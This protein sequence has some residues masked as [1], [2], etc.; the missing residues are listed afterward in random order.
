[1]SF[2]N[3]GLLKFLVADFNKFIQSGD[4]LPHSEEGRKLSIKSA[5]PKDMNEAQVRQSFILPLIEILGWNK[6]NPLEV[7]AEERA[8]GGFLD[9][10]LSSKGKTHFVIEIKRP[11]VNL[12]ISSPSGRSAAY[13]GIGYARSFSENPITI[14]T[15]FER[16]NIYHSYGM[17]QESDVNAN[18]LATFLW[19]DFESIE[20]VGIFNNITRS[21]CEG[22]KAKGFFDGLIKNKDVIRKSKPLNQK[23]L[24]DFEK[25][26]FSLGQDLYS[27]GLKEPIAL[28]FIVQRV[29][30]KLILIRNLQD[31]RADASGLSNLKNLITEKNI[32]KKLSTVVFPHFETNLSEDF[33][34]QNELEKKYLSTISDVI[35]KNIILKT[36][37]E[38]ENGVVQDIYDFSI[39]P[40][41]LLGYAYEQY[42][43]KVFVVEKN[44]LKLD[45]KPEFKKA[46]GICYTPVFVVDYIIN[47]V[48]DQ[49]GI[50]DRGETIKKLN[51]FK[52]LD[53]SCGSGSFLIRLFGQLIKSAYTK[54]SKKS[55]LSEAPD[56]SSKIKL[57]Q[58]CVYGVDIDER[59]V[60]I[61]KLSLILKLL[62]GEQQLSMVTTGLIPDLGKNIR[63]GNSLISPSDLDQNLSIEDKKEMKPLDWKKFLIEIS[64]P[65]G[66]SAIIGNPPYVRNQ[67]FIEAYPKQAKILQ[68]RYVSFSEGNADIYLPFV[69]RAFEVLRPDGVLSYIMPHRFWANDYG[70][71]VRNLLSSTYKVSEVL[72]FRAEQVFDGPTTY[73][74]IMTFLRTTTKKGYS[75]SYIE[76]KPEIG[77]EFLTKLVKDYKRRGNLSS[78][79]VIDILKSDILKESD[80]LL[81]P[82]QIRS[83]ILALEKKGTKFQDFIS[84]KGIYQGIITGGD[85]DYFIPINEWKNGLNKFLVKMLK[86]SRDMKA[87]STPEANNLLI[88]P[89]VLEGSDC[90]LAKL[91][92]IKK[93]SPELHK[94]ITEREITLR[95][96]KSLKT[97]AEREED[98]EE[99]PNKFEKDEEGE[100]I[101]HYLEDDY[102]K[103]ARNQALNAPKL[104]KILVPSLFRRPC[105]IPDYN[106]EYITPGSGS[107]GGGGYIFTLRDKFISDTFVLIGLLSNDVL[108]SWFER[109]GDLYQGYYVGVD[110]KILN[111]APVLYD[112][113]SND[114]KKR[115]STYVSDLFKCNDEKDSFYQET[116]NSLTAEVES[117]LLEEK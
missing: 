26:R 20:A 100:L 111:S 78:E 64:C 95:K 75:F 92:E 73:T 10:R 112:S 44:K 91:A 67:H 34:K 58:S 80:W 51:S 79:I 50:S 115:I 31:R 35:F 15:N 70:K 94:V 28:N 22:S 107:G 104:S 85:E 76:G 7:I 82:N 102:Y 57:L 29:L 55:E 47:N 39:I 2:F 83:S 42:L 52:I 113:L 30:D 37:G 40:V 43:G 87:F 16:L 93:E 54:P 56:L 81:A 62:E 84:D 117:L 27:H 11:S 5:K 108:H 72:N 97:K 114:A 60:E 18:L 49:L 13:Q 103:Y 14:V 71:Q 46:G 53:P 1:V 77:A 63:T 68:K 65:E 61:T 88:Y 105:F 32:G 110:K 38:D 4:I 45:F 9:I 96:R 17:V 21:S 106:G 3:N 24:E 59:A 33:F 99:F 74:T 116:L 48:F 101:W 69:E 25:W 89:Y 90:R 8:N 12:D 19:K 109:R 86:G 23:I 36:Y 6:Q 66:F 41:E 98:L